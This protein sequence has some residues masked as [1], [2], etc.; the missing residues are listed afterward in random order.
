MSDGE[1]LG[2]TRG[3]K[4][5]KTRHISTCCK[6]FGIINTVTYTYIQLHTVAYSSIQFHTITYSYIQLHNI[7]T[8]YIQ[9]HTQLHTVTYIRTYMH[10]YIYITI[11]VLA[12][13]GFSNLVQSCLHG[14]FKD[15]SWMGGEFNNWWCHPTGWGGAAKM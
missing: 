9:L 2:K 15:I 14:K 4:L 12:G 3:T 6:H 10:I 13:L 8:S 11:V 7:H 1:K 5:G